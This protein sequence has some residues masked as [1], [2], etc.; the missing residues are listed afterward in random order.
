M[1]ETVTRASRIDSLSEDGARP[2]SVQGRLKF[3]A[4]DFKYPARP[5]AQIFKEFEL[6]IEPGTTV[7]LVRR[8][9]SAGHGVLVVVV[10]VVVVVIVMVVAR[11]GDLYSVYMAV[12]MIVG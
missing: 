11:E 8:G 10:V 7:A 2:L 3:E 1:V 12:L 9:G 5:E 4:V 6:D